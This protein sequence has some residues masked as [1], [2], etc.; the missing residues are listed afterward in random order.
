MLARFIVNSRK[1]AADWGYRAGSSWV[2]SP[3]SHQCLN[4][5]GSPR[6][7][8]LAT[9]LLRDS[10]PPTGGWVLFWNDIGRRKSESLRPV[11]RTPYGACAP[12]Y[13]AASLWCLAVHAAP[14]IRKAPG[15]GWSH[16]RGLP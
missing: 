11:Y 10:A 2:L 16:R 15:L 14:G 5:L 4:G 12:P 3:P 1:S 9:C 6:F 7:P 8:Y 13:H